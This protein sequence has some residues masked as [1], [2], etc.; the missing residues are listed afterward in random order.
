MILTHA[1]FLFYFRKRLLTTTQY[2]YQTLFKD[3]K[4]AD[5]SVMALGK[6][7]HL[8]KVYL[9]QS[10]YFNSMFNGS[11]RETF[12]DFISIEIMDSKITL[13]CEY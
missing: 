12:Q 7:W 10:P 6:V 3:E 9:C 5:I 8:H 2:I 13:D 11:W 1:I 4:N